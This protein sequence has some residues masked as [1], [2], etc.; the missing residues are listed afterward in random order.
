MITISYGWLAVIGV[1][2]ILLWCFT[3]WLAF[4]MGAENEHVRWRKAIKEIEQVR[5][6]SP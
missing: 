3:A 1:V 2:L 4:V 6:D 5:G